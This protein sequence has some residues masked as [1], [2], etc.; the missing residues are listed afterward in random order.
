MENASKKFGLIFLIL[1]VLIWAGV[2]FFV[3]KPNGNIRYH[4]VLTGLSKGY[5]KPYFA[6]FAP[7][8]GKQMGGAAYAEAQLQ[9]VVASFSGEPYNFFSVGSEISGTADAYFSR[10]SAVID[11]LNALKIEAMLVGNIEFTFGK[12]RLNEL[13]KLAKFPFLSSNILE[14]GAVLPP[15]YLIPGKIFNVAKGLKIGLLG[16]SPPNTPTLTAQGNVAGLR[17]IPPGLELNSQVKGLREKGADLIILLSL[18]DQDRLTPE[19]WNQIVEA[20]PDVF[21][22]I[23]FNVEPPAPIMRDGVLIKTVSGYNQGK[24]LELLDIELSPPPMKILAYSGR[25]IPIF[26]DQLQPDSII[27]GLLKRN[28]GDIEEIKAEKIADF[29]EDYERQFEQECAIGDFLAE[30]VRDYFKADMGFQNSGGIQANIRK[31]S[32]TLGDL[33]DVLPFNN[34]IVSMTLSGQDILELLTIS[35]SLERGLLQ[36]SSCSYV[37]ANRDIKDFEL[38]EVKVGGLPIVATQS[39]RV[40]TNSFLAE[41]GDGYGVFRKGRNIQFGPLQREAIRDYLKTNNSSES[42]ILKTDGRI[43]RE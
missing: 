20:K 13:S 1:S 10:G 29:A 40:S 7:Y 34:Q 33:F 36:V 35:A 31:G 38:K 30:I 14:D 32:F 12:E 23:D 22:L 39:Y 24:E 17:F 26:C 8:R 25:R 11:V 2:L 9:Q 5:I 6:K 43:K 41:G 15:S 27:E 16:L 4:L 18:Y 19:D 3:F 21:T 28:S 37:F 42:I